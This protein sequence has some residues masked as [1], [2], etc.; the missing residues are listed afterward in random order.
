[1]RRASR[2]DLAQ[3]PHS[4]TT[5]RPRLRIRCATFHSSCSIRCRASLSQRLIPRASIHSSALK[6]NAGR[7]CSSCMACEVLPEP[8]R[9]QTMISLGGVR[10]SPMGA[11]CNHVLYAKARIAGRLQRF[12]KRPAPSERLENHPAGAEAHPDSAAFAARFAAANRAL[13]QNIQEPRLARV[14]PQPVQT[15][16]WINRS[17]SR[18]PSES[19]RPGSC[20]PLRLR[21]APPGRRF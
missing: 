17:T 16:W 21:A 3:V 7:F 4:I 15:H 14:L 5:L 11:S 19:G 1:M 2:S 6:R 9:P 13:L 8:G 20:A 10:S 12:G 18:L